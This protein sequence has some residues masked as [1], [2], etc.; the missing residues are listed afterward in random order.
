M[1]PVF[2][3][4]VIENMDTV[5]IQLDVMLAFDLTCVAEAPVLTVC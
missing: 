4:P 2:L 5:G 1:T 3:I